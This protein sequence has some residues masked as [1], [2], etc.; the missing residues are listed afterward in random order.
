MIRE[1]KSELDRVITEFSNFLERDFSSR[2]KYLTQKE[3]RQL[4][5]LARI[6]TK[7]KSI[8]S[9]DKNEHKVIP[10]RSLKRV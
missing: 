4:F 6:L 10:F 8:S 5:F 2:F 7:L 9:V 3:D 1:N